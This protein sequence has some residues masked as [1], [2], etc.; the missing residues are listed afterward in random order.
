[1]S[2]LKRITK[3]YKSLR[4]L[5]KKATKLSM[6]GVALMGL[7]LSSSYSFAKYKSENYGGGAAGVATIGSVNTESVV[8]KAELINGASTGLYCFSA[9]FYIDI[10][11]SEVRRMYSLDLRLSTGDNTDYYGGVDDK[12]NPNKYNPTIS[13]FGINDGTSNGAGVT[14]SGSLHTIYLDSNSNSQTEDNIN[15]SYFSNANDSG[16]EKLEQL[17]YKT[18]YYATSSDGDK[19]T[20]NTYTFTSD[21]FRLPI[22]EAEEI[23][24]SSI[25]KY[26]KVLF[27]YFKTN[28]FALT[29]L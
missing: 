16:K 26:Y 8:I 6:L 9:E 5:N 11:A 4:F 13:G 28:F 29:Q 25:R 27:N 21:I 14:Y 2:I 19:Y 24:T 20:W 3:K 10:S 22:E 18:A 12:E 7:C 17:K 1:M 23:T 15:L